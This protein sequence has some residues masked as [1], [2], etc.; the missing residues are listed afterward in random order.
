M[1]AKIINKNGA[2]VPR[3]KIPALNSKKSESLPSSEQTI[4]FMFLLGFIIA[5]TGS[6]KFFCF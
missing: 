2:N 4:L 3:C 1:S 5:V 6:L